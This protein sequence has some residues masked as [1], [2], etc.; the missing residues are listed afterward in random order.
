MISLYH[1]SFKKQLISNSL[2][3]VAPFLEDTDVIHFFLQFYL[4]CIYII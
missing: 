1:V 4:L 3:Q 2:F